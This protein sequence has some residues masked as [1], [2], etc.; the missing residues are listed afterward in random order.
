MSSSDAIQ[1]ALSERVHALRLRFLAGLPDR[2]ATIIRLVSS[3]DA[4]GVDELH[5]QF[6]SLAGTAATYSVHEIAELAAEGQ[7]LCEEYAIGP[8]LHAVIAELDHAISKTTHCSTC[9]LTEKVT[10]RE[11]LS[12]GELSLAIHH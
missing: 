12:T 1:A 10:T 4:A 3:I 5:R 6:H 8:A 2:L 7:A 11:G 9:D